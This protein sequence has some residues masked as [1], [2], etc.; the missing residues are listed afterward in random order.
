MWS[1]WGSGDQPERAMFLAYKNNY[2]ADGPLMRPFEMVTSIPAKHVSL[3]NHGL[4]YLREG[5]AANLVVVE[6]PDIPAAVLY[7]PPRK[8]VLKNGV[9]IG[10]DGRCM[11]PSRA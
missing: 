8:L 7:V 11:I 2:R 3:Q 10:R 6:A 5:A 9:V 4:E 1:P